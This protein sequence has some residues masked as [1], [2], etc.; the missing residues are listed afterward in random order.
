MEN[1]NIPFRKFR[2]EQKI[3]Y[4]FCCSHNNPLLFVDMRMGKSL[5]TIRWIKTIID[6]GLVLITCPY[7]GLYGWETEL[8]KENEK[9]IVYVTGERRKR[10]SIAAKLVFDPKDHIKWILVN[11]EFH[12]TVTNLIK[13]P[14]KVWVA[15]E[16]TY[17][18]SDKSKLR[19]FFYINVGHIP[20]RIGLTGT[21]ATENE[22][23]YFWLTKCIEPQVFLEHNYFQ[24]L[25][26][27]FGQLPTR[28]WL[29]NARGKK[30]ITQ[31]LSKYALYMNRKDL[32]LGG[33]IDRIERICSIDKIKKVYK[34]AEDEFILEIIEENIYSE[35]IWATT[36]WLWLR[37]L[38]G[39]IVDGIIIDRT[40]L[41][42][43]KTLITGELRNQQVV[44]WA[45]Y[46]DEIDTIIKILSPVC[47]VA[48]IDGRLS[49]LK[50]EM[51]RRSFMSTEKRVL[52][53]NPYSLKFGADLS[54]AETV[55]YFS[56][57]VSGLTYAQSEARP[58]SLSLNNDLLIIYLLREKSVEI[59]LYRSLLKK[60]NK[61]TTIRRLVNSLQQRRN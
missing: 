42:E 58:I 8:L 60:E 21:P 43:L 32:G 23:Q 15:D 39:G 10:E 40:K 1:E 3:M 14:Y 20:Y 53:A 22:T 55:I 11:P 2:P 31:R 38:C 18:Q 19:N 33:K 50:R 44:I 61:Q 13:K 16:C 41:D 17:L 5:V 57:P 30:Y 6:S 29:T 36:K 46:N 7:S 4:S 28:E 35:T 51:A 12:R 9:D 49:P 34:K 25:N 27:N 47:S 24:F 59:D 52:V 48:R 45:V 54:L 26:A 56:L 37:R